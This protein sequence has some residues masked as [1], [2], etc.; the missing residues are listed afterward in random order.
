LHETSFLER[1][2]QEAEIAA[3][4]EHRAIVPVYDYGEWEGVPY[5]VMRLMEG[6]S[7]DN[8]LQ[9]GPLP[10]EQVQ[11]I[12]RQVSSALDYAHGQGVLHRDLKPSNIL[13]DRHGDAYIT[14]FGIARI[15][16][17]HEKLTSTG[18]VGT[19]AY[20]SPEQAQGHPLDGRSDIYALGVVIFEM[21]TGR[22][23]FDGDTPYSIAVMQVT[24]AP[25]SPRTFNP[26]IPPGV[27]KVILKTLAKEP[28]QR[29]QTAVELAGALDDADLMLLSETMPHH[30]ATLQYNESDAHLQPTPQRAMPP[31]VT[32][33]FHL[34]TFPM[35]KAQVQRSALPLTYLLMAT[36]LAALIGG[37]LLLAYLVLAN[38]ETIMEPDFAATGVFRLTATARSS[39][40]NSSNEVGSLL[41]VSDRD[42]QTELYWLQLG[43]GNETRLTETSGA[44]G[45][46]A[47]SNDGTRLAYLYDPD[48]TW[49]DSEES[50]VEVYLRALDS[51]SSKQITHNSL[52][53]GFPTWT[54]D[55]LALIYAQVLEDGTESRLIRYDL[56]TQQ[57]TTLYQVPQQLSSPKVSPDGQSILFAA[58][59]F[60][61]P[62]TSEIWLLSL[63]SGLAE[64]LT[65]NT[66]ADWSPAWHPD[67]DRILFLQAGIGGTNIFEIRLDG[68]EPNQLYD[69]DGREVEATYSHDGG[70]IIWVAGGDVFQMNADGSNRRQL[71]HTED[72]VQLI[73]VP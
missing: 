32:E 20:M 15:L 43:I 34:S 14:D 40:T 13:L 16:S 53:E 50:R 31:I 46:P 5:I 12:V 49:Q 64:P 8:L 7:V 1:F 19:P 63:E 48:G 17:R 70:R 35:P 9:Q 62:N 60:D 29:Y 67:G 57:E 56:E 41:Y 69:G 23:P 39:S 47:L 36:L 2:R 42:G 59:D 18:V 66:M 37:F 10:L 33:T 22:R 26:N 58:S 24:K 52:Q 73:V 54:P 51:S 55:G 72:V 3:R 45:Y 38:P 28:H 61:N 27:E 21:L 4:L 11:Q 6:R 65:D 30:A 44:E 68:T 71:T 25:P